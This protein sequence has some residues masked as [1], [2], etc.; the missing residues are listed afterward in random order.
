MKMHSTGGGSL[1]I[2]CGLRM[3][4]LF[5]WSIVL[6]PFGCGDPGERFFHA[7]ESAID[8]GALPRGIS[9]LSAQACRECHRSDYDDWQ[10]SVH[11]QAWVDVLFQDS[12]KGEPSAWCVNC[13]APLQEQAMV[14][15]PHQPGIVDRSAVQSPATVA[16]REEGINCAACHIRDGFVLISKKDRLAESDRYHASRYE[17]FL[18]D[19]RFCGGCH[20]FNFPYFDPGKTLHP[21]PSP[22]QNTY[23]EWRKS[24]A[25]LIGIGCQECHTS[26]E[27]HRV[28]GPHTPGWLE[29]KVSLEARMI[30]NSGQRAV[31]VYL[32][33]R[34]IAHSF[35]TGDLFRG[36]SIEIREGERTVEAIHLGR[37]TGDTAD[38]SAP[39]GMYKRFI[40][41]NVLRPGVLN[42]AIE[43][44][45]TV[46]ITHAVTDGNALRCR[47]VYHFR[48][49]EAEN[50]A[51]KESELRKTIAEV[52]VREV[53]H[54]ER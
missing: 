30:E 22:M 28:Y 25:S 13:H 32:V 29:G 48:N 2:R 17:P 37:K 3:A 5:L 8:T 12:H 1:S 51:R 40:S 33:L 27:N 24:S 36:L 52:E 21:G 31:Q 10:H 50:P 9:S 11:G 6:T 4:G 34:G 35:P 19:S 15:L 7:G 42:P 41:E 49:R 20:Q 38:P 47:I 46:P 23:A 43:E 54:R 39:N 18:K 45:L 26:P 16:L 44:R 53:R 14:V